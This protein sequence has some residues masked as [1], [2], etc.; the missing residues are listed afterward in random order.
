EPS[1]GWMRTLER[2]LCYAYGCW[3]VLETKRPRPVDLVLGRSAGL[4]STLFAPV[5]FPR[6]PIVNLFD[7]HYQAASNDLMDDCLS[8]CPPAYRHWRR[9]ANAIDLLD[10]ENNVTPW[11]PTQW[12]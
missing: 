2:S 12:Q 4:G 10:L 5:A 8:E 1:V 3:E 9:S 7:Y 11:I 6:V